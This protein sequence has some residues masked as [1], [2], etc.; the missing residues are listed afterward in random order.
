MGILSLP[1]EL[2]LMITSCI[3]NL[4]DEAAFLRTCRRVYEVASPG[5]YRYLAVDEYANVAIRAA[6]TGET[7]ILDALWPYNSNVVNRYW[8]HDPDALAGRRFCPH[9][10]CDDLPNCR[11]DPS[12]HGNSVLDQR[13]MASVLDR[14][15]LSRVTACFECPRRGHFTLLH[16]AALYDDTE[17]ICWLLDHGANIDAICTL[18]GCCEYDNIE[19]YREEDHEDYPTLT[20]LQLAL[21]NR[22]EEAAQLL[23]ER[24]ASLE[25][26]L[27]PRTV[28][29]H[30]RKHQLE[31]STPAICVAAAFGLS[32]TVRLFLQNGADI[33]TRDAWGYTA[34]HHAADRCW[35]EQYFG[36]FK[37]L[38]E[39][40]ADLDDRE[41]TTRRTPLEIT[42]RQG[43]FAAVNHLLDLG[44]T[45]D[46]LED[47]DG[48]GATGLGLLQFTCAFEARGRGLRYSLHSCF[49]ISRLDENDFSRDNWETARQALVLKLLDLGYDLNGKASLNHP[50]CRDNI[51]GYIPPRG[52]IDQAYWETRAHSSILP[53]TNVTALNAVS[54]DCGVGLIDLLIRRGA[55]VDAQDSNCMT[56]LWLLCLNEMVLYELYGNWETTYS[57][58]GPTYQF[59]EKVELL[60]QNGAG[61]DPWADTEDEGL[62][63]RAVKMSRFIDSE[64][65]DIMMEET[66]A[67]N[68]SEK[69]LGYLAGGLLVAGEYAGPLCILKYHE[70]VRLDAVERGI[71]EW[72]E[73]SLSRAREAIV[74]LLEYSLKYPL[75]VDLMEH[76][77]ELL[78][79]ES[80]FT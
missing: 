53:R 54:F 28:G 26:A 57:F 45:L 39:A 29:G 33:N 60:L 16:F 13:L 18:T 74:D 27:A 69:S 10:G 34:L 59:R 41:N 19:E 78:Q 24:A 72:R 70:N 76:L 17:L 50:W 65:F 21:C 43:N 31:G 7:A 22:N 35:E 71:M 51:D 66:T 47:E 38:L 23:M 56:L 58:P 42:Y 3:N 2:L 36:V 1:N 75:P 64:M 46:Q 62:S 12:Y 6:L 48:R 55:E 67:K 9:E 5:L 32:D 37:V 49:S 25:T 44:A 11:Y 14:L 80:A 61:V 79:N 52:Q 8:V 20:A 4:N 63:E 68:M 30:N 40:G 15:E 73:G 77:K